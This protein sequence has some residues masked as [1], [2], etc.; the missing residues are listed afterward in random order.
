[1]T[2]DLALRTQLAVA[3]RSHR[4]TLPAG[5][6]DDELHVCVCGQWRET[7]PMTAADREHDWDSH[8]ADVALAVLR[9]AA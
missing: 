8:M 9:P 4:L 1:M 3:M 7:Y 6:T 2:F 5:A